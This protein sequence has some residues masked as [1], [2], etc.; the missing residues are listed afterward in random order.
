MWLRRCPLQ[1]ETLSAKHAMMRPM[2]STLRH[3]GIPLWGYKVLLLLA[4]AIWGLGTVAIKS[5]VDTLPPTWIVGL[6]FTGAGLI[7]GAVS[8]PKVRGHVALEPRRHLACGA[9]LGI[10]LFLSYWANSTGLAD[11]TASNS[12]FLTTLYVVI[13]PFLGWWMHPQA[14][15]R[16][17]HRGGTDLRSGFGV[18]GLRGRGRVLAAV[19][20]PCHPALGIFPEPARA[21]HGEVRT[22]AVGNGAHGD[23][24]SGSGR[25]GHHDGTGKRT[26]AQLSRPS[27]RGLGEPGLS[28]RDGLL[29]CLV[30]AKRCRGAGEIRRRPRCFWPWKRCSACCSRCFC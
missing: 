12:S 29:C 11:T 24:V 23:P 25:F 22:G 14:P 19:R 15:H 27:P 6:R 5:T 3:N 20:R 10:L 26:A 30:A 1:R 13:I 4:A 17:Q 18:C 7:L 9:I 21:V 8:F 28:H 16:L 2:L